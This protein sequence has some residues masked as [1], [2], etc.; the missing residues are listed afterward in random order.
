VAGKTLIEKMR[1]YNGRL[2]RDDDN[3]WRLLS[4]T[5]A[6]VCAVEAAEIDALVEAGELVLS[7]DGAVIP[8]G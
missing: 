7:R 3:G 6:E 1:E 5:L 2:V 8:Q 4:N